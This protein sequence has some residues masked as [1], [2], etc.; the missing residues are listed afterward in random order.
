MTLAIGNRFGVEYPWGTLTINVTG[1]FLIGVIATLA[2]RT[3]AINADVR[4]LLVVGV[5]G[6]YTTFSSFMLESWK[7]A[8]GPAGRRSGGKTSVENAMG[9]VPAPFLSVE[10]PAGRVPGPK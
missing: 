10:T 9:R 2:D 1:S 4:A 3:G 6:G 7:L 8:A 5:L